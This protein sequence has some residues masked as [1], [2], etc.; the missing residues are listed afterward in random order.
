MDFDEKILDGLKKAANYLQTSMEVLDRNDKL[1]SSNIW[2]IGAELEYILFLFS[3]KLDEI[4]SFKWKQNPELVKDVK[5]VLID[6]N[7]LLEKAQKF[8][9]NNMLYD[10]YRNV[11]IAR[12]YV[13]KIQADIAKKKRE[14]LK[15]K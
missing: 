1:F 14:A 8:V 15:K 7:D 10:A 9:E 12:H 13:F 5:P 4:E 6:I 3:L 11:Y 2:H